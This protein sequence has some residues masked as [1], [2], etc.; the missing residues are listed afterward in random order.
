MSKYLLFQWRSIREVHINFV[1]RWERQ[2]AVQTVSWGPSW[3]RN[4]LPT[5]HEASWASRRRMTAS[6]VFKKLALILLHSCA[7]C[8]LTCYYLKHDELANCNWERCRMCPEE[9]WVEQGT[10]FLHTKGDHLTPAALCT[11]GNY[12]VIMIQIWTLEPLANWSCMQD[13]KMGVALV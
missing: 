12:A 1:V 6:R 7:S 8:K 9:T 11:W 10:N 4:L 13:G 2:W 3:T 5:F